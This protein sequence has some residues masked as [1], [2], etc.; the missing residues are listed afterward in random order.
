MRFTRR[1]KSKSH[2]P[3]SA[4]AADSEVSEGN[5]FVVPE[6]PLD[7]ASSK[8]DSPGRAKD[9]P[10]GQKY[11]Q[12]LYIQ[13]ESMVGAS[14]SAEGLKSITYIN[15]DRNP[16]L[17][18]NDYFT[19]HAVFRVRDFDGVTPVDPQTG[20]PKPVIGYSDY[21]SGHKRAFSLQVSGRFK[22]AWTADDVLFGTFFS[23]PCILPRGYTI[24]LSL[25]RRIDSSMI[26]DINREDPYMCSPLICA[27][28]LFHVH[29]LWGQRS[30]KADELADRLSQT[31]IIEEFGYK[32]GA[33]PRPEP[34]ALPKWEFGGSRQLTEQVLT[35]WSGTKHAEASIRHNRRATLPESSNLAHEGI[36]S[37]I[38]TS[39]TRSLRNASHRRSYFLNEAHRKKFIYHP[40]TVYSFDFFSPY[41]D[42]NRMQLKLGISIDALYYLNGQPLRYQCRSRDGSATFFTLEIGLL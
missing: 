38:S 40:D 33:K 11:P 12:K 17:I 31:E 16:H 23:K 18:N 27:M 20:R 5:E 28:N 3:L 8:L 2:A 22:H 1:R 19:G 32:R 21:F 37:V 29:P 26:V 36:D 24:A 13:C 4:N 41:V 34:L 7:T 9:V 25:A 35:E 10:S 15:D 14:T 42:L 6:A 39:D 30:S